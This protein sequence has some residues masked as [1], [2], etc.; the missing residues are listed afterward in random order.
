MELPQELIEAIV[1]CDVQLGLYR[2]DK[3]G[4]DRFPISRRAEV[5]LLGRD[6]KLSP[7]ISCQVRELS[8]AGVG[9]MIGAMFP[10]DSSFVLFLRTAKRQQIA[11]EYRALRSDI[12]AAGNR[13]YSLG[14]QF[15]AVYT[16]QS[17]QDRRTHDSVARLRNAILS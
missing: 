16:P 15:V 5:A 13:L 14:A 11:L 2:D 17:E 12:T 8:R 3:R 1:G 7:R 9:I 10:V 6:G 4:A